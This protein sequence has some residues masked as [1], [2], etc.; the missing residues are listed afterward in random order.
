MSL[1]IKHQCKLFN[2]WAEVSAYEAWM[3][4]PYS[5]FILQVLYVPPFN[6]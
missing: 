2:I 1:L 3:I 6:R 4:K 5:A